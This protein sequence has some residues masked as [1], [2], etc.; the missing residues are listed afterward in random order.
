MKKIYNTPVFLLLV[1]MVFAPIASA[2]TMQETSDNASRITQ[3][4][5][6][7]PTTDE[8]KVVALTSGTDSSQE[9]T[10]TV[11]VSI[12]GVQDATTSQQ[13]A[14][15]S[16]LET[17]ADPQATSTQE[18][19]TIVD[20]HIATTDASTS[21]IVIEREPS[22][23]SE[24]VASIDP[25]TLNLVAAALPREDVH[26]TASST[27]FAVD[28]DPSYVFELSGKKIATKRTDPKHGNAVE[29]LTAQ[30]EAMVD[31]VSG[32]VKISGVCTGTYYVV[33]LFKNQTDYETDPR[34]FI[35]NRA[36][37]CEHGAYSYSIDRLPATLPNG[38]YYLMVG[39]QSENG[40]WTPATGLTEVSINR[41]N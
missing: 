9:G 16:A 32:L 18:S 12:A 8:M 15:A 41:S 29:V 17:T 36:Y 37:P 19:Q 22:A 35:V 13:T 6:S 34:S 30:T 11:S 24:V 38:T 14:A 5:T 28:I 1:S 10:T 40:P 21:I 20:V 4:S 39:D 23:Q 2:Q 31:S 33:L 25:P 26:D 27:E 3:S 7:S